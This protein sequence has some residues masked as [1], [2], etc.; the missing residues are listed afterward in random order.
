MANQYDLAK[1]RLCAAVV[2]ARFNDN[3]AKIKESDD[4]LK[5]VLGTGW[6]ETAAF[7][8][9][10]GKKA[11][12]ALDYGTKDE[13]VLLLAAHQ[14]AKHLCNITGLGAV[15]QLSDVDRLELEALISAK[16]H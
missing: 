8:F 5:S 7:Q 3:P 13:Q 15:S 6:S 2:L 9:M 1:T 16:Q 4:A 12:A 10:S 14:I 11:K